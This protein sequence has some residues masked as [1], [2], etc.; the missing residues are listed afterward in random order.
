MVFS[1][2]TLTLI[3]RESPA[4]VGLLD[5]KGIADLFQGRGERYRLLGGGFGGG[6]DIFIGFLVS[7]HECLKLLQQ[8]REQ[9][10]RWTLN[11]TWK[12]ACLHGG[13]ICKHL[14]T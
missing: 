1:L 9:E 13:A 10:G 8:F 3:E 4:K 5:G 14:S 7:L 12:G 6:S 2:Y 11:K